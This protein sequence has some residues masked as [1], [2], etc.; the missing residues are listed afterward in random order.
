MTTISSPGLME[1][2]H[3]RPGFGAQ[4]RA[5]WAVARYPITEEVANEVR[6][7][8]EARRGKV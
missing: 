2:L 7:K 1:R 5:L 3:A 8:L 4:L 6:R